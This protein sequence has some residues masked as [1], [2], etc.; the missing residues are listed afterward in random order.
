MQPDLKLKQDF[1]DSCSLSRIKG[2]IQPL[3][4][5]LT[6]CTLNKDLIWFPEIL[7]QTVTSFRQI[8]FLCLEDEKKKKSNLKSQKFK[9][10][11]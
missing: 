5:G 6:S 4:S 9:C 10:D 3:F 7:A 8:N 1:K 2:Q 11:F